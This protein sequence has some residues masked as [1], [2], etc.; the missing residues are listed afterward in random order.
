MGQNAKVGRKRSF[1]P[2]EWLAAVQRDRDMSD[3]VVCRRLNVSEKTCYRFRS[4]PDNL[5]YIEKAKAMLGEF[6]KRKQYNRDLENWDVFHRLPIIK[7]WFGL[8]H[9]R[10]VKEPRRTSLVRAVWYVCMKLKTHPNNLNVEDCAKLNIEMRD[11]YYAGL[12]QPRGLAYESIRNGLRSFFELVRGISGESLTNKGISKE[13]LPT[14]GRYSKQLVEKEI[15]DRFTENLKD[16]SISSDEYL[17]LLYIAKFMYYTGTRITATL[18]FSFTVNHYKLDKDMWMFEVL[19][20][21]RGKGKKWEKYFIGHALDEFKAYVSERF[22]YPMDKL[23]EIMPEHLETLFPT[24]LNTKGEHRVRNIFKKVLITS[25]IP[26]KAFPPTHIFR[27]TF[28]QEFLRSTGWN[29]ELCAEIGGWDSTYVL[30]KA[31]G[32]MGYD[33]KINGLKEAMGI[34][35]EKEIYELRW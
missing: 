24:F 33:A 10:R 15:R 35:I 4:N 30:K 26:Y 21:G 20:K 18:G 11:L 3:S 8:L 25:K 28:A 16:V 12:K 9:G 23:E 7:E 13:N 34:P 1:T 31:Y 22:N 14:Y 32:E 2:D 27:H 29:Y 5:E 17:E 6:A 19:D